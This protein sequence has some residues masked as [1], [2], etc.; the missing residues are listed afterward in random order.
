MRN[1]SLDRRTNQKISRLA[2]A[3]HSA[4]NQMQPKYE[5]FLARKAPLLESIPNFYMTDFAS[6]SAF[7]RHTAQE[8]S[9]V[10][11]DHGFDLTAQAAKRNHV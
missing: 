10:L 8:M 7:T 4:L 9:L 5:E 6:G 3:G 1:T 11:R 2:Q